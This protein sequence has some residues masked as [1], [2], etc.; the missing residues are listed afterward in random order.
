LPWQSSDLNDRRRECSE[1]QGG[2]IARFKDSLLFLQRLTLHHRLVAEL[3]AHAVHD[4]FVLTG[5]MTWLELDS[6]FCQ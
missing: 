6:E 3:A 2:G 1:R 5:E 4:D